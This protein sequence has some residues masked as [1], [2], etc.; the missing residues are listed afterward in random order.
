M[1]AGR[2]NQNNTGF[3]LEFS[4]MAYEQAWDL[5]R[6]LVALRRDRHIRSDVFMIMEHPAVFTLGR[7]GGRNHLKVSEAELKSAKIPLLQVERGGD[8]TYHG[9]GQVIG[10]PIL[11]LQHAKLSVVGYVK[12]LETVMIRT[13]AEW[14]IQAR[15]NQL[16][17]GIWVG[18]NKLGS[19][20][21]AVRRGISFHGFALNVNTD[22]GPFG[23]INPCG[24]EGI[25]V[26]SMARELSR[27][28][29]M[30]RVRAALKRHIQAV[31]K[32]KLVETDLEALLAP[33]RTAEG[34]ILKPPGQA[35]LNLRLI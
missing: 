26:T 18:N 13:A 19:V 2:N 33:K 34:F 1:G 10:Y 32:V 7:R 22:L 24:L 11:N 25:G 35:D 23:W 29:S 20:G 6:K 28:I 12:N 30:S 3:W 9:P 21:I 14:G 17:R 16:N 15:R 27:N 4:A 8:I 5:Q 31:F